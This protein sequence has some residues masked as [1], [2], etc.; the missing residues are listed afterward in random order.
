LGFLVLHSGPTKAP[1]ISISAAVGLDEISNTDAT[2]PGVAASGASEAAGTLTGVGE[3]GGIVWLVAD[4]AD[5][6]AYLSA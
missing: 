5:C 3:G 1:S 2:D 4:A 6:A